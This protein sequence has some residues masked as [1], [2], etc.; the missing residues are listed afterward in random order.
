MQNNIAVE[1]TK[2][3]VKAVMVAGNSEA[4][5]VDDGNEWLTIIT[6]FASLK[7]RLSFLLES[8]QIS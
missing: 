2:S 4:S 7:V 1:T 3:T 5:G 6:L 8:P